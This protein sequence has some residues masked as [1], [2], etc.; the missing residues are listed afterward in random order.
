MADSH[1]V[2]HHGPPVSLYLVVFLCLCVF[3]AVS[4]AVNAA[5]GIGSMTG[6][7]IILAVAICKAMLVGAFFMHLRWEWGKLYFV[8]IPVMILGVMMMLVL[9]PDIVVSWHHEPDR[10]GPPAAATKDHH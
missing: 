8:I 3:T 2:E 1:D 7:L 4:F 5:F 10:D 9:M 6:L